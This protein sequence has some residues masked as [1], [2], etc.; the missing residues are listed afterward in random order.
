MANGLDIATEWPEPVKHLL[1]SQ[2]LQR[3]GAY[4]TANQTFDF[5]SQAAR[6]S[7][8]EMVKW[9][10]VHKVMFRQ[11]IP[12][13]NTS[14]PGRLAAGATGYGWNN[15]AKPLSVMGYLG[16][17]GLPSTTSQLPDGSQWQYEFHTVPPMAG[18]E[19]KFVQNSGWAFAVPKT[20]RNQAV[21]WDVAR[22]LALSPQAMRK[23]SAVTNAL[24][25]L[26]A[27][28]TPA[29]AAAHPSLGKVQHLLEHGQWVGYIPAAAS[30][31]ALFALVN[32]FFAA[33]EGSKTVD[34]ALA[35]MQKTANGAIEQHRG[36]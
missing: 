22:S 30:D 16:T 33:A 19:H 9:L 36:K 17:W 27:N 24:P 23:W 21:A 5:T 14:V 31:A 6:D 29:A 18:N 8:T 35:D 26:R 12:Q 13:Q 32:N 25:A 15:R 10:Q 4:F 1:L 2:I 11:L 3:G 20:S 34:E 28:G 7:L